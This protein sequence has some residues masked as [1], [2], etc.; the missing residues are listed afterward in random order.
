MLEDAPGTEKSPVS[1]NN[2]T[3]S[4]ALSK[5]G[6]IWIWT[7]LIGLSSGL[8]YSSMASFSEQIQLQMLGMGRF[9]GGAG[10][11]SAELA[12][13]VNMGSIAVGI[14]ANLASW[15]CLYMF[16][17][18]YVVPVSLMGSSPIADDRRRR[19][20]LMFLRRTYQLLIVSAV[21]RCAPTLFVIIYSAIPKQ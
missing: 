1:M 7:V 4:I 14:F 6:A 19:G 12:S 16:F 21:A 3:A 17:S 13:M 2:E 11:G 10:P 20:A 18:I 9:N 8:S 5:Y 15:I